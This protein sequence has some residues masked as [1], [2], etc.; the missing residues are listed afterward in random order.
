MEPGALVVRRSIQIAAT[1]QRVWKDIEAPERM[2]MWWTN[3]TATLQ[4]KLVQYRPGVGG[5]FEVEGV[6]RGNPF[7][8]GGKIV[9][10][11][12]SRELTMEWD[13]IPSQ[14]W[15]APTLLTIRLTPNR[16]GTLV[17][18][19]QHGFERIGEP[20]LGAFHAFEGGWG[21]EELEALRGLAEA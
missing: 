7:H 20:A 16:Y 5:W 10:V 14:G 8:F 19:L 17:E 12:A 11:E 2:K 3:L 18:I 1:P 15:A 13:W 21:L 6:H 4:Q 9:G